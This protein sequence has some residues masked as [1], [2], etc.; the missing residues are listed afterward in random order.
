MDWKQTIEAFRHNPTEES[1]NALFVAVYG[2]VRRYFLLRGTDAMTAEDLAQRVMFIVYN[3]SYELA[4]A[5]LFQGW[6]FT[7]ARN[8]LLQHWRRGQSRIETVELEPLAEQLT[9]AGDLE[10]RAEFAEWLSLLEPNERELV[11]LRFVEGLS[12]EELALAFKTPLGTVKSRLFAVRE[13][14]LRIVE[15]K[16]VRS[17][18]K[19]AR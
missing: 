17:F 13:K 4:D 12:Y 3:K 8:E 10:L 1:F 19:K 11:L 18:G 2:R 7:I 9:I 15:N 6:L 14:L 16:P 5:G